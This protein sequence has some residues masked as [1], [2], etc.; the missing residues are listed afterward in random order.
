MVRVK[1]GS[2]KSGATNGGGRGLGVPSHIVQS[3]TRPKK[4]QSESSEEEKGKEKGKEKVGRIV[5]Y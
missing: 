2:K 1:T 4:S 5:Y 3:Q